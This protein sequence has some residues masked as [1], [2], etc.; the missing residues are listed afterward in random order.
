MCSGFV[1]SSKSCRCDEG[2]N[3]HQSAN[4]RHARELI[5]VSRTDHDHR[6][7]QMRLDRPIPQECHRRSVEDRSLN[8]AN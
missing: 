4:L 8:R 3:Q 1:E 5:A 7:P 6:W 2:R